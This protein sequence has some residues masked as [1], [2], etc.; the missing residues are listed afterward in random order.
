LSTIDGEPDPDD[1]GDVKN[2]SLL[3]LVGFSFGSR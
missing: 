1:R 3:V 2:T